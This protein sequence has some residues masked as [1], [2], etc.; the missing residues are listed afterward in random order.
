M[1]DQPSHDQYRR[2]HAAHGRSQLPTVAD[3]PLDQLPSHLLHPESELVRAM[4]EDLDDVVFSAVAGDAIALEQA[5]KLWPQV[6]AAVGWELVEESREQYLRFAIDVTQK[7]ENN[8]ARRPEHAV[9]A[10]EIISL[11]TDNA[12]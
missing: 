9:A 2:P 4:L 5:R 3:M 11:L 12:A 6:V 10:L 7:F 1:S 8:K